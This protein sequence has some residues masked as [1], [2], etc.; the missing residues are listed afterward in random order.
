MKPRHA[1]L[2]RLFDYFAALTFGVVSAA[3]AGYAIP[4]AWPMPLAMAAGMA[5]GMVAAF[6]VLMVFGAL[7]GG[8]EIL[9][10]SMQAGMLA[11]MAGVM[12]GSDSVGTLLLT[13]AAAGGVVQFLL[14]MT[15]LRLRG[16]RLPEGSPEHE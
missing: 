3:A 4:H 14:H 5:L 10:M 1:Y 15:D 12:A 6:P 16:E 2:L 11:G 13:G 7:L 8:F 9:M